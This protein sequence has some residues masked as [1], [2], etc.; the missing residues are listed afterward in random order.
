MDR[1]TLDRI[2]SIHFEIGD[3]ANTAL[4]VLTTLI[5]IAYSAIGILMFLGPATNPIPF[6]IAYSLWIFV[7]IVILIR[8]K[9]KPSLV[10][11][12]YMLI[13]SVDRLYTTILMPEEFS[14]LELCV[15]ALLSVFM[16]V[17]GIRWLLGNAY[18]RFPAMISAAAFIVLSLQDLI[19]MIM[20][21]GQMISDQTL[22]PAVSFIMCI[23][24]YSL[25]IV[26]LMCNN[27]NKTRYLF[28]KKN[29]Q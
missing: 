1:A 22:L 16:L 2:N 18:S 4:C 12:L 5:L 25:M 17:S 6:L 27:I 26:I 13:M 21:A 11:G 14:T 23:I 19:S 3:R 28:G 9:D 15:E 24:I 7:G 8:Y 10:I 20:D 29:E